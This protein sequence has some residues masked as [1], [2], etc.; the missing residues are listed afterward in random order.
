MGVVRV[1]QQ[2]MGLWD[3]RAK[4]WLVVQPLLAIQLSSGGQ[5]S[6]LSIQR[7]SCQGVLLDG[8]DSQGLLE[9]QNLA[10]YFPVDGHEIA[11]IECVLAE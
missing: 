7:V 2:N 6:L 11:L 5:S 8:P 3:R 9:L 1:R 10:P 4:S